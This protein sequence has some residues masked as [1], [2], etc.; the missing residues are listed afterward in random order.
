MVPE[1]CRRGVPSA[2]RKVQEPVPDAVVH[3]Q[4]GHPGAHPEALMP[5]HKKRRDG[6]GGKR[7]GIRPP[8]C[9]SP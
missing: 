3:G 4:T 5:V 8:G 2:W 9:D 7:M 1:Y 6:V